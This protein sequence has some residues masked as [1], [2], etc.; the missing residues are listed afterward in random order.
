MYL[1]LVLLLLAIGEA[2]GQIPQMVPGWPYLTRTEIWATT[3]VPV[4]VPE[5]DDDSSALYSSNITWDIDKFHLDGSFF[6][7][8]PLIFPRVLF[9]DVCVVVDID[10]DG[11]DEFAVS[12]FRRDEQNHYVRSELYL[13]DHDGSIF[14]DFPLIFPKAAPPNVADIDNDGEYEIIAF[15]IDA[16]LIFCVDRFGQTQPGWP[17]P[18]EPWVSGS[19]GGGGAIAD[20]DMDGYLEYLLKGQR[21]LYC[22]RFDGTTQPGFPIEVINSDTFFFNP[23]YGPEIADIDFDGYPEILITGDDNN[24]VNMRGFAAVYEHTGVMKPGWPKYVHGMPFQSPVAA[25]IDHDGD[26]E[27]LFSADSLYAIDIEGDNL[28]GWPRFHDAPDVAVWL[29]V[30][31]FIVVD[32][33][34]DDDCEIFSDF[35]ALYCDIVGP[36][37]NYYS[38]LYGVDHLGDLLPGYPLVIGGCNFWHP[39][40]FALDPELNRLYMTLFTEAK[41]PWA[42]VDSAYVEFYIFPDSTGPTTQWPMVSHDRLLTKNYNFVDNVTS[43]ADNREPIPS[44][45]ILKPNYPNPFNSVTVIE[46]GLPAESRV[47]VDIY[48]ILG[49]KVADLFQGRQPA[50]IHRLKW[51]ADDMPSGVYLAVVKN[52][53]QQRAIRMSLLK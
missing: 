5:C 42:N 17:V 6:P 16:D 51:E 40:A 50:G 1:I 43:I 23:W 32:V 53:R 45:F 7:G 30:S 34:G 14:P 33:D 35:N 36:D 9:G 10:H 2:F 8:F 41:D 3:T 24:Y 52:D 47:C 27:M 46:Y 48:D 15:D 49:R 11:F 28:P 22:F 38:Y 20:L 12:G 18:L 29:P 26:L 21:H 13:I 19:I 39:P 25:D 44:A 4:P 37:T 31:D